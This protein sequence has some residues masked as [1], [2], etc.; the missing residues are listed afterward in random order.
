[1]LTTVISFIPIFALTGQSYKLFAPL[2]W[3]K[4]FTLL[5]AAIVAITLIPVLCYLLIGGRAD[6]TTARAIRMRHVFRWA[7]ALGVARCCA[8]WRCGSTAGFEARTG[9]RIWFV[10]AGCVRA[11]GADCAAHVE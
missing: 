8:G 2:A 1:V 9:L 6:P 7:S 3:T 11:V 10:A 5:A 4:T